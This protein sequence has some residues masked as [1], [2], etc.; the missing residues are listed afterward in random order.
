ML[1]TNAYKLPSSWEARELLREKGQFWTPDWIA[2]PMTEY[3]L[4]KEGGLLF[5]P[6]VGTGAFFR[7]AK[8]IAV[9]KK[10]PVQLAGMEIDPTTLAQALEYGLSKEEIAS[11]EIADFVL[12][13]PK[14]KFRAIVANPPYI[15]HHRLDSEKKAQ[16]KRLSIQ[17]IGK[18]LDG[19][20][21]L[22]VYF[23]IR[24]LSLL[25]ENGRLAFIMPADT[26]E[27][28]F[29]YDLWT[30][31]T[32]N[33]ALD[34]VIT[35]SPEASPFPT[36]DTN[37][38]ILFIRRAAPRDQFL[39]VKC[40]RPATASLKR[41]VRSGFGDISEQDL[42]VLDRDLKEG[43]STG[44]SR[45]PF[46]SRNT[47]Y[48]LG[49]FVRVMR[50]IATGAN[51][52][53]FMTAEK[54]RELGIPDNYFV[55]AVGRTRDVMGDKVTHETIELLEHKGRP[56]LLLALEGDA[57]EDL[58][59]PVQRYLQE[60]EKLG[61]PKRPLI[62]QRTPW[63]K[64]EARLPPPFLFAYLGRRNLRFIRNTARVVPL[65]GF[66]CVYPR[67]NDE[68]LADQIW[69]ILNH[70]DTIANLSKIGKSYG[71]GAIKVEPRLLEKLPIPD[72]VVEQF[73]LPMQMRLFEQRESYTVPEDC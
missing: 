32:G 7:A 54:A 8:A 5:D 50:G 30:W 29:A 2:E 43:L 60:G 23:L 67:T 73:G 41:W 15:R 1:K 33:F 63:Y 56:T 66:L 3:V 9:E 48:V 27:G 13:P 57:I 20:A 28:K 61:L 18:S 34:A 40:Y 21:G 24:A 12:Q 10:L 26:C 59:E 46:S 47:K 55:K 36:I 64:M 25:E 37:P 65:T 39:W 44:F 31:I 6:A 70:P 58:P 71:G 62:S 14:M 35:F 17:I 19:R 38:L 69:K 53:F 72:H 16:L 4:G 22:H 45:E 52:F 68:K 51:D 11:V 42:V 49:D